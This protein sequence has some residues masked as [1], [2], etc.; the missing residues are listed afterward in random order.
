MVMVNNMTT[1]NYLIIQENVVTNTVLWDGNTETWQPPFDATMLVQATT[2]TKV[3]D[4]DTDTRE[5]V[6]V[7]SVGNADIGFTWDGTYCTTNEPKPEIN[8]TP[9]ETQPNSNGTQT[10]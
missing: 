1:Q 5:Y 3:W 9:S 2:P 6:L 4:L 8:K 7:D 10:L